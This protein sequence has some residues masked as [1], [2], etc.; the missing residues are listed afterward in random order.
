MDHARTFLTLGILLTVLL[1]A[2]ARMVPAEPVPETRMPET[3]WQVPVT[4]AVIDTAPPEEPVTEPITEAAAATDAV[5]DPGPPPCTEPE[6]DP[7][8]DPEPEP[9]LVTETERESE[10]ETET[11][12][13]T[14]VE[15]LSEEEVV[16]SWVAYGKDY[17]VRIGLALSEDCR[18]CWDTPMRCSRTT[19]RMEEN[20]RAALDF[21]RRSGMTAVWIWAEP[22]P[23]GGWLLYIGYG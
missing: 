20:L 14:V 18:D 23:D 22:A 11:A 2:C 16:L 17:A 6:S 15:T 8:P 21:Y 13:E 5:S 12:E 19:R 4:E 9:G 10:T 7:E 3:T 1:R